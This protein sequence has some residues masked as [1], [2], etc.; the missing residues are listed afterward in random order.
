MR[1]ALYGNVL[2]AI[3]ITALA[4]YHMSLELKKLEYGKTVVVDGIEVGD[5]VIEVDTDGF[6]YE[7]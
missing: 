2:V 5:K 4:R 7:G 1:W 6:Y 3:L